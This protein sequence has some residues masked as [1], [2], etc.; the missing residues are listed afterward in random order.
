MRARAHTDSSAAKGITS[1]RGLGKTRHIH[2]Q[3]LWVQE[4]RAAGDFSLH[5]ESTNDNVGDLMTKHLDANKAADFLS[6][7][8]Y[9]PRAGTAKLTLQ[10]A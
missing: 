7:L 8:G 2:T 4:R 5:K 3:Y 9:Q 6:R 10:A 1:R